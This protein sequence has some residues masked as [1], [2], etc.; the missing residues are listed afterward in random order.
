MQKSYIKF[1]NGDLNELR[2]NLL[3]DLSNES[4]AF[5][6]GK[7][8]CIKK[9]EVIT[10]KEIIYTPKTKYDRRS[11]AFLKLKRDFVYQ[12]LI[13]MQNRADV[14]TIIDV[15]THPF[16]KNNVG[17]SP[18]DDRD[19]YTFY[20]FLSD[21]FNDVHYGSIVLSQKE[22]AA[23]IWMLNKT[24]KIVCKTA[25]IKTQTALENISSSNNNLK[26]NKSIEKE[27]KDTNAMF[28]R[29]FLVLG[30]D[31]MRRITG[32]EIISIVGV[33]G[34]GSVVAEHLIHMGF[35]NVNLFDF[36]IIEVSN[37]NRIV[38]GYYED[39]KEKRKKVDVLKDH[40]LSINPLAKVSAYPISTDDP[41]F[42]ELVAPSDWMILASDNFTSRYT[43][44]K[45][46]FK[47]FIP[48]ISAG[49]NITV[50]DGKIEDYSGE[51]ITV[52][53]GDKLCL[54][55]LG[56]MNFI[57][58]AYEKHPSAE[59]REKLVSRGYVTGA[60]IK[61]PAVKTLNTMIGTIAVDSLIHQYTNLEKHKPIFVYES[62]ISICIYEDRESVENRPN[63]CYL[64]DI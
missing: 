58:L 17:F 41:Q 47:Y 1:K 35:H 15:H 53:I 48:F 64:C 4:F 19:E 36:D 11:Q 29:G 51:V 60:D 31:T 24:G 42:E 8:E 27:I 18:V 40:L 59:I 23:R 22:Y 49:V 5:L 12:L 61:E 62:N 56:R 43:C 14:D 52:R 28:N 34:L 46:A 13:D 10:I 37:L 39:A 20:S 9:F 33:G 32:N 45:I 38:G 54:N 21:T 6:F 55:C 26:H 63:N 3:E 16:C 30:I 57:Q 50:K 2:K 7:R 25:Q 44:Q